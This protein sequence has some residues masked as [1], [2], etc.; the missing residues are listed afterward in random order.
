MAL[1]ER[2]W[3]AVTASSVAPNTSAAVAWWMSVIA[4][5]GA[6][7]ACVAGQV[8]H[9]AQLDLRIVR[10]Q[11]HVARRRDEGLADAPAFGRAD[12][13]VLQVRILR[14][15]PAGRGHR[16]VIAGVHAAGARVDLLG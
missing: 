1:A 13:D 9:D 6:Q 11:Q 7:Q 15:Q 16:L 14:R 10:R 12:R 3:S 5:E 2:R 8:R 4:G